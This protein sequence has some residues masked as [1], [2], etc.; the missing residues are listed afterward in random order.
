MDQ[1]Q[2]D[3]RKSLF[4][5]GANPLSLSLSLSLSSSS[6]RNQDGFLENRFFVVQQF[7]YKLEA[8]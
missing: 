5:R 8:V 2:F 7:A 4:W 6:Q 3:R 1:A